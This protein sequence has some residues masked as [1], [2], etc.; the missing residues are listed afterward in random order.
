VAKETISRL[1]FDSVTPLP[2]AL[3]ISADGRIAAHINSNGDIVIWE[4]S[5]TKTLEIISA[6]QNKPSAISLSS[7][8]NM[9]AIGYFD[10]QL[11]VRS[12]LEKKTVRQ[13]YGHSGAITALTFSLDGN[14]LASGGGGDDATTQ[15]W[16]VNTGRCLHIFDSRTNGDISSGSGIPVSIAFSGDGQSLVVN[17]WYSRFYDVGR[18]ITIWDIKEGIEISTWDV[19]PP[20]AD[21]TMRAGQALGGRGRLLTYTGSEGLMVE[22]LD[23]CSKPI[24][25]PTGGYADTVGSDPLGR[26]VAATAGDEI[27][28]FGLENK[29]TSHAITLPSKVIA[30]VT[31]SDGRSVFALMIAGVE[32]NGNEHFIIGRDAETVTKA[33][34]YR[35]PVPASFWQLPALN[36]KAQASYCAPSD[37]ARLQQNFKFPE[38]PTKLVASS[39]LILTKAINVDSGGLGEQTSQI[40][41]PK[42]LYFSQNEKL[43]VLYHAE[44]NFKSGVAVWDLQT[45]RVVKSRFEHVGD[46]TL[47]LKEGWAALSDTFQNLLTGNSLYNFRNDEAQGNSTVTSDKDTGE[48]FRIAEGY[49]E[50][51]NSEGKRLKDLKTQGEVVTFTARNGRLAVLYKSGNVHILEIEPRGKSKVHKLGLKFGNDLWAE[52]LALS[53]DGQYLLIAFPN[54]SGDGPTEYSIYSLSSAK[55][56]GSGDLLAPFPSNANRGVVADTRTHHLAIWDFDEGSIIARLPRHRSRNKN[57][58]SMPLQTAISDDGKLVASASYDGLV[59]VWDIDA[60]KMVGE[61]QVSNEVSAIAFDAAGKQLAVGSKKGEVIIFQVDSSK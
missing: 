23:L 57:G 38:K 16:E 47:R 46:T 33:A 43:F 7:D 5:K 25:L 20:N 15:L 42:E 22:R 32:R 50:H 6:N 28:F 10:S 18:G 37:N 41:P 51:Y 53:A 3:T 55:V 19:A 2:G 59:R 9:L 44:S 21:N 49:F 17:E 4:T 61:G 12:R 11:I 36:I 60:H 52:D 24:Q 13:F 29:K 40:N 54:A 8:G 35:I 48:V 56:V 58:E 30:L 45:K 1:S 31:A 34:I 39:K 14:F 26:W 27:T